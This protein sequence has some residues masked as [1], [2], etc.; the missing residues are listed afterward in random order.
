M[1]TNDRFP[2][3]ACVLRTSFLPVLLAVFAAELL[4]LPPAAEAGGGVTAA[5]EASLRA[6]LAG[7][8]A[9]TFAVDGTITL[10]NTLVIT[11]DTALDATGHTVTLSGGGAVRLFQVGTNVTF[12]LKGLTL[13]NGRFLGANGANGNPP[14]PGQDG[15][16][17]GILN[18]GGTVNLTGCTLTNHFVQGG[19]AGLDVANDSNNKGR[20]GGGLGAAI[21]S[22][23]GSVNLTNCLVAGNA[24]QGGQGSAPTSSLGLTVGAAGPACGGAIYCAGGSLNLQTVTLSTNRTAGGLPQHMQFVDDYGAAGDASGGAFFAANSAVYVG[25]SVLA[26]NTAAGAAVPWTGRTCGWASGGAVFLDP[27]SSGLFQLSVFARNSAVGGSSGRSS[28][29]GA[30]RGGAVFVAGELQVVGTTFSNNSAA[31]GGSLA[32]GTGQGGAICSTNILR[33]AGST[34]DHNQALGPTALCVSPG[35]GKG[36]PG[37]GGALW[38]SGLLA[39]TNSTLAANRAAGGD[40]MFPLCQNAGG[41][42]RGGAA[43]LTGGTAILVNVTIA[44]N[45]ADGADL[46]YDVPPGPS[47]GGGLYV[48]NGTVT[49]RNSIIAD[50]ANGGEVWGAV[51]DAG[52]NLCSDGTANFTATGSLN[53]TDPLLSAF[54]DN[55]GPT[56]TMALLPGSPARDAIPSGFPPTDQRGVARPQGPA[57]D[58]GAFEL[59]IAQ[60]PMILVNDGHFGFSSNQFGFDLSGSAGATVVI[61]RSTNLV[62]WTALATNTL[63]TGPLYFSDPAA[64][65]QSERFYRAR[66]W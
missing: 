7:G 42:A 35:Y 11:N 54:S 32:P 37:E 61:E 5:T 28:P 34:F 65:I 9:V 51:T 66:T 46:A 48:T 25:G 22:L 13:A 15:S 60:P 64:A 8:G 59:Q 52:Y 26:S 10:A 31:G 20:G 18:L 39:A 24:A 63:G 30:G 56:A 58:I 33:V 16:G 17:A 49:V 19:N 21:G 1:K 6:A 43:C 27:G 55:G 29:G 3:L 4:V 12:S 36:G 40:V 57:A 45:R 47:Q 62:D 53:H 44:T 38:S 50:S 14:A 2:T 41:A 23:G